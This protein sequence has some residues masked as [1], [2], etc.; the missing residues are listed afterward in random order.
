MKL[1]D[2]KILAFSLL[3]LAFAF[4]HSSSHSSQPLVVASVVAPVVQPPVVAPVVVPVATSDGH[5][6]LTVPS[7]SGRYRLAPSVFGDAPFGHPSL[8]GR[9]AL[10]VLVHRHHFERFLILQQRGK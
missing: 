9:A 5:L 6:I 3:T 10:S 8:D 7:P 2:M 4:Y 1:F